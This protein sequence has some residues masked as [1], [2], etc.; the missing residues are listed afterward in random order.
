M[1]F[2]ILLLISDTKQANNKQYIIRKFN[3]L[4]YSSAISC[5]PGS[6]W[7]RHSFTIPR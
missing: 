3:I 7:V 5:R 1:V 2:V 6:S 4:S